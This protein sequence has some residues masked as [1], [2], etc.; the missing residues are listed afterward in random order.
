MSKKKSLIIAVI[1]IGLA[2]FIAAMASGCAGGYAGAYAGLATAET[3]NG[4]AAKQFPELDRAKRA[5][6]VNAAKSAAEGK[7]AL[8]AWDVTAEQLVKAIEGTHASAALARQA[9]V[10]IKAGTRDKR[11]LAGWIATA[12]KLGIELKDIL[13]A[14]G[15]PMKAVQ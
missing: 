5:S 14:A 11:E 10:E 8:D 6:I 9:L 12:I 2:L 3:I 7:A 1:S 13:A 15:V 4:A